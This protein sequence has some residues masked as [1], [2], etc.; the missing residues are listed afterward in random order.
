MIT[1]MA[2]GWNLFNFIEVV[3]PVLG[4]IIVFGGAICTGIGWGILGRKYNF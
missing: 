2:L 4:S 1:G 3:G